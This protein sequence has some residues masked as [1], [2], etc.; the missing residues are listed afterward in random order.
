VFLRRA[1]LLLSLALIV[2]VP[3]HDVQASEAVQFNGYPAGSIVVRTK[4]RKLYFVISRHKAL[5]YLV[6]VGRQ[7]RQWQGATRISRKVRNPSWA[8]PAAVRKD[9]PYLPK[10]VPPGKANPLGAAVLIL[11]GG[12]YGIHGTNNASSIGKEASYGCIRM[13]NSDILSLYSKVRVGTKV[14]VE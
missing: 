14:Y 4:E 13:R 8:P 12:T 7:G 2:V 9:K 5:R 10:V 1:S 6:A 3:S 11:G